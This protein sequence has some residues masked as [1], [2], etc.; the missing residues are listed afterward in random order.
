MLIELRV[1][2]EIYTQFIFDKL[3]NSLEEVS[4]PFSISN[5]NHFAIHPF[6]GSIIFIFASNSSNPSG[7]QSKTEIEWYQ[8]K[9]INETI[10]F[11]LKW[12][13][14]LDSSVDKMMYHTFINQVIIISRHPAAVISIQAES[15]NVILNQRVVNQPLQIA[16]N[17]DRTFYVGYIDKLTRWTFNSTSGNFSEQHI[18]SF[19]ELSTMVVNPMGDLFISYR[20][21]ALP[22]IDYDIM[23]ANWWTKLKFP[24]TLY[25]RRDFYPTN[26]YLLLVTYLGSYTLFT[27]VINQQPTTSYWPTVPYIPPSIPDDDASPWPHRV[28]IGS[29]VTIVLSFLSGLI[30]FCVRSQRLEK[31]NERLLQKDDKVSYAGVNHDQGLSGAP[32]YHLLLNS[33][34]P[35]PTNQNFKV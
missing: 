1:K 13:Q 7:N 34:V 33:N 22:D 16:S 27:P 9:R 29:I 35:C 25:L 15:G 11:E 18:H 19:Y 6:N 21:T 8:S 2:D 12:E 31:E 26:H 20:P 24:Y 4:Y 30:T 3:N 32:D 10:E 17:V 5:K 28:M 14:T 23:R